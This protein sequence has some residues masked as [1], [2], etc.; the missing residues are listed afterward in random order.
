MKKVCF[1]T[2]GHEDYDLLIGMNCTSEYMLNAVIFPNVLCSSY[3]NIL[4]ANVYGIQELE[5]LYSE[6]D[7]FMISS[8][9]RSYYANFHDVESEIISKGKKFIEIPE[10]ELIHKRRINKPLILVDEMGKELNQLGL[11]LELKNIMEKN[12]G[13]VML[14]S[15][16]PGLI[17]MG[18]ALPYMSA[19]KI[20]ASSAKI[21]LLHTDAGLMNP[22]NQEGID[23]ALNSMLFDSQVDYVVT[24][25][26]F[27]L[28]SDDSE[29]QYR[30][31]F[32]GRY[33]L[34]IDEY[35]VANVW[36]D[37]ANEGMIEPIHLSKCV[38]KEI[39][40]ENNGS[41]VI[42]S[43]REVSEEAY[44]IFEGLVDKLAAKSDYRIM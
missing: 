43:N 13:E 36:Y 34:S 32:K 14:L 28:C 22:Y 35:C 25:A 26:P 41:K 27:N 3:N 42:L 33:G 40:K 30:E 19:D 15:Q 18:E 24:I 39:E 12:I 44:S 23:I 17:A 11:V 4:S 7:V 9:A 31:I 6:N 29:K 1:F 2:Q 20:N 38:E 8:R 21:C 10:R 5:D 16:N 37:T